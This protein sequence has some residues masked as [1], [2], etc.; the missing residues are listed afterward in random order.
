[1]TAGARPKGEQVVP[2][3]P[4][5]SAE[6][7]RFR[8]DRSV[9]SDITHPREA[10]SVF[11]DALALNFHRQL[12]R[13][14]RRLTDGDDEAVDLCNDAW[15]ELF[16]NPERIEGLTEVEAYW[17]L[18]DL[19]RIVWRRTRRQRSRIRPEDPEALH[20]GPLAASDA[21]LAW[22]GMID[23]WHYAAMFDRLARLT[24]RQQEVML[25]HI[26]GSNGRET[27]EILGIGERTARDHL[28]AAEAGLERL[29]VQPKRGIFEVQSVLPPALLIGASA[30]D[31][32]D[33]SLIH[34]VG[35]FKELGPAPEA[36]APPAPHVDHVVSADHLTHAAAP[37]ARAGTVDDVV[38]GMGAALRTLGRL[39]A[40]PAHWIPW[41]R[42]VLTAVSALAI[43][44]VAGVAVISG[45]GGGE[46]PPHKSTAGMV[47]PVVV[48]VTK[49]PTTP[50]SPSHDAG[51]EAARSA[52]AQVPAR[53]EL[54]RVTRISAANRR[55]SSTRST[56]GGPSGARGT[57]SSASAPVAATSKPAPSFEAAQQ[58]EF[59]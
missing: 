18:Q 28:V 31:Q 19:V 51:D 57:T 24:R 42:S 41:G 7:M 49:P 25:L 6:S 44:V 52:R 21:D 36:A 59:R 20:D 54:G 48:T 16:A 4:A 43:T 27:A 8:E 10:L 14:A 13:F 11:L 12:I 29:G 32:S 47:A 56:S 45:R 5:A 17:E 15:A 50:P 38:T 35:A 1:M 23:S 33:D 46:A 58:S 55:S 39:P 34:A 9:P 22:Q 26:M 2:S 53:M 40:D 3:T 37:G 30:A